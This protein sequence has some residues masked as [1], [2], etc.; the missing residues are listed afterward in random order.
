MPK[1]VVK[2]FL[3]SGDMPFMFFC[4]KEIQKILKPVIYNYAVKEREVCFSDTDCGAH[5]A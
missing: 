5:V 1:E 4:K 3:D 2:S